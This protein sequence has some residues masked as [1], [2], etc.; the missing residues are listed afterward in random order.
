MNRLLLRFVTFRKELAT[1]WQAFV[2]PHTPVHLK[3]LM[4]L[5]PAYLLSPIDLI[6]DIIPLLGWIDD[7]VV[8]PLMVGWIVRMLPQPMKVWTAADGSKVI[9]GTSRRR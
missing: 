8:V 9:E 4:L 5:V 1:L 6:P 7:F 2:A 3:A